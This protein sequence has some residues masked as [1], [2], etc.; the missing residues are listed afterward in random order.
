MKFP[1]DFNI[2]LVFRLVFP[3]L[4][5]A[6]VSL[7]FFLALLKWLGLGVITPSVLLP[8]LAVLFGW[9]IVLSD[10]PIYMFMEGRRYWLAPL[11]N[12]GIW[13]QKKRLES[14]QEKYAKLKK[15]GLSDRANEI[16]IQ[17]LDYPLDDNDNYYAP[18]PTL[19]GNL[20]TSYERYTNTAYRLDSIFYW[21]RLWVVLD[22]DLR[23][24]LDEAQAVADSAVYVSFALLV[25]FVILV[26]YALGGWIWPYW[27][28]A[29][30][31]MVYLPRPRDTL[32]L[33][34]F[35]LMLAY[36]MYR[37]GIFQQRSYGELFKSLFD[38]Y[39]D[40]LDKFVDGVAQEVRRQGG[41]RQEILD[42]KYR[43]V[44]RYLRWHRI[45]R[46]PPAGPP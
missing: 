26:L 1:F 46:V 4:V 12:L 15:D 35:P 21:Y 5:V 45:H 30:W 9:L 31:P 36:C 16:N 29:R 3:G 42:T 13:L 32:G 25:S 11:R 43:V 37:I 6:A 40:K 33:S 39:R 20:L 10:Q 34:V 23:T 24:S 8:V 7:P 14:I 17:K 41:D 28:W 2:T 38:Q 22:K 27:P 19:L 44:S 18:Y